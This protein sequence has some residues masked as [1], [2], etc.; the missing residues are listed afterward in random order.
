M[1]LGK[2]DWKHGSQFSSFATQMLWR[3]SLTHSNSFYR[4]KFWARK[5]ERG[6]MNSSISKLSELWALLNGMEDGA[7]T[8]QRR[9]QRISYYTS[10]NDLIISPLET[11]TKIILE[12][13]FLIKVKSS[14]ISKFPTHW[15][16]LREMPFN[17]QRNFLVLS[18]IKRARNSFFVTKYPESYQPSNTIQSWKEKWEINLTKA[19]Q[20]T[21]EENY[22]PRQR[23]K[24]CCKYSTSMTNTKYV[25]AWSCGD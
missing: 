23:K 6:R 19:E 9:R 14:F 22:L 13:F 11:R 4:E 12:G 24:H 18:F 2:N 25:S 17:Q 3:L 7:G 16:S 21:S 20:E 5:R 10:S 1:Q 15:M 8:S